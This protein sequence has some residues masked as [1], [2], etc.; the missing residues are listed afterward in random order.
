MLLAMLPYTDP[1][2]GI[3]WMGGGTTPFRLLPNT[4][5]CFKEV[6]PRKTD[7]MAAAPAPPTRFFDRSTLVR[8]L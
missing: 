6:L 2:Y 7:T 4:S 3:H 1:A 5:T 8:A